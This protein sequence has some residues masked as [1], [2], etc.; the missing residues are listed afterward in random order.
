MS[1]R[2]NRRV[3][4][5]VFL[6]WIGVL[7]SLSGLTTEA[8]GSEIRWLDDLEVARK[9]SVESGRPLLLH[10]WAP[11]CSPCKRME[12][13]TFVDPN[14]VRLLDEHYIPVKL[15][16]DHPANKQFAEQHGIR[17][18]P[19]DLVVAPDGRIL[20]RSVQFLEATQY[21]T[22]LTQVVAMLQSS[23]MVQSPPMQPNPQLGVNQ[24]VAAMPPQTPGFA[25]GSTAPGTTPN[26]GAPSAGNYPSYAANVPP[27][28]A[29]G[30]TLP[31]NPPFATEPQMPNPTPMQ[32]SQLPPQQQPQVSQQP[33]VAQQ[34]SF[35]P[36]AS[37]PSQPVMPPQIP[38]TA[39]SEPKP[40]SYGLEGYCPV[41]LV[42]NERWAP[43]DLR[44]G[45]VHHGVTYLFAGPEQQAQFLA[46]PE[47][48]APANRGFD[49]VLT[50]EAGQDVP[51]KRQHGVFLVSKD[52]GQRQIYLFSSEATLKKFQDQM[53]MSSRQAAAQTSIPTQ[54]VAPSQNMQQ[55]PAQNESVAPPATTEQPTPEQAAKAKPW[56]YR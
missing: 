46:N 34:P 10:F 11:W 39:D 33:Q 7:G 53:E 32:Q 36:Q 50:T 6:G 16:V 54:N 55:Y 24:A 20:A 49:I 42:Q 17:G 56:W 28:G 3:P 19:A 52:K 48:Y 27:Q 14:V 44:Y 38:Q 2:R 30:A 45:A 31:S 25:P 22:M 15:N 29:Y 41:E 13:S 21:T 37:V 35:Q 8:K 4:L 5:V 43:G 47:R 9:F 26:W 23:K 18:V 51:G 40:P 12:Q 1:H